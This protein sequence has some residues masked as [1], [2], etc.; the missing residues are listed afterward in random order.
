MNTALLWF[1]EA[2]LHKSCHGRGLVNDRKTQ[3][4]HRRFPYAGEK[5]RVRCSCSCHQE[6]PLSS[7]RKE[8]KP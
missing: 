5:Y 1:C 6:Q 2:G 8:P 3:D 4:L 7:T